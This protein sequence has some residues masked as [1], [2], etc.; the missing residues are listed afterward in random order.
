MSKY[1]IIQIDHHQY[2][3]EEGKEYTVPKFSQNV[4]EFE[5][6]VLVVSDGKK[7]NIGTPEA[8]DAKVVLDV[9][10]HAKGEKVHTRVYRAKSRYRKTT[11]HRKSV[12]KFK[13]KSIK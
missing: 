13:V 5:P 12:T 4:G 3:V 9:L 1:A 10:E 8:K 7:L 11:G 6:T 2:L